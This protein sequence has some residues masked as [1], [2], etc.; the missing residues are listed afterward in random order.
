[1]KCVHWQHR[2]NEVAG[3]VIDLLTPMASDDVLG[4]RKSSIDS[5]FVICEGSTSRSTGPLKE[6]LN[7]LSLVAMSRILCSRKE[8][9]PLN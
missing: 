4:G 7:Y 6:V 2:D 5:D 8:Q 9:N 3:H 1:M